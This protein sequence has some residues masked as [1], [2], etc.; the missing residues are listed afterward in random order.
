MGIKKEKLARSVGESS[1]EL[2]GGFKDES[3]SWIGFFGGIWGKR[4]CASRVC[5]ITIDICYCG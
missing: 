2:V 1:N 3:Q 4:W 5:A